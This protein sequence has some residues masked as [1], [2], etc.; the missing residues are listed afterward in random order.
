MTQ[1]P[2]TTSRR[3]AASTMTPSYLTGRSTCRLR[4]RLRF[5]NSCAKQASYALSRSPGPS[6]ECTFSAQSTITVPISFS[7]RVPPR[8]SAS[9]ALNPSSLTSP[10][11]LA[12]IEGVADGFADED[13]QAQ[14]DR[15]H[16]EA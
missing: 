10:L 9:S 14:H 8:T 7:L 5:T 11:R 4:A 13:Q 2:T 1:S 15:Q 16:Q 3:Y 6:A 12:G